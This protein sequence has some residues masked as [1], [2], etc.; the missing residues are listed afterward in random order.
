[1]RKFI[2]AASSVLLVACVSTP[3][4]ANMFA[5]QS[6]PLGG[7]ELRR[8]FSDAWL[9]APQPP[10]GVIID[11]PRGEMFRSNGTYHR[12]L[13]RTGLEGT[14][15]IEGDQLCVA[16]PGIP[17]RCRKVLPLGGKAYTLIDTSDGTRETLDLTLLR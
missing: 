13:G 8:L 7:H 12:V 5:S 3:R 6:P 2:V 1:M 11:H 9:A 4:D 14:F 16:G 15:A 17:K 10:D